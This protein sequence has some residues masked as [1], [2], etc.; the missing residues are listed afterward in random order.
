MAAVSPGRTSMRA[1]RPSAEASKATTIF[2]LCVVGA[3]GVLGAL[4][5]SV[6]VVVSGQANAN[7]LRVTEVREQVHL[8]TGAGGNITVLT[9]PEGVTLVDSGRIEMTDKVLAA[10]RT[11]TKQPIRYII[12]TSADPDQPRKE[13]DRSSDNQRQ[14]K[15]WFF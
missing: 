13:P 11:L 5:G 10:V 3:L 14:V 4:R 1:G 2:W 9:F 15:I 7:A 6:A 12:N 8:L